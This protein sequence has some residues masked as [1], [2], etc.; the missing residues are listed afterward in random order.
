MFPT[1]YSPHIGSVPDP[2]LS[3]DQKIE[4]FIHRT[5]S[6][7]IQPALDMEKKAIPN[8]G[9]AQLLIVLSI[10]E[11]I[12]KYR[13]GFVGEGNS[14]KYFKEGLRWIFKEVSD[15]DIRMLNAFYTSV[16][17]GLYH[18]G[19]TRP[20]VRFTEGIP[21]SFGFNE[22]IKALVINPDQFVHDVAIRFNDYADEIRNPENIVLRKSF[23]Q[24]FND[25]DSWT[26]SGKN[27]A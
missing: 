13:A 10:F 12:G 20:N 9:L 27:A 4:F 24:R 21:G 22:E 16:R 18:A 7:Q 19:I 23:E 8:R 1:F 25:D 2:Q 14:A 3:L 5:V 17:C 15:T 6:L 11:M 26:P